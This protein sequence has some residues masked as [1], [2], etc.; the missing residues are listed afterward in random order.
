MGNMS[1]SEQKEIF[2]KYLKQ[3]IGQYFSEDNELNKAILY[4]LDA[5]GKRI[6][7]LLSL[8]F[9]QGFQGNHN[10][11][12]CAALAVEMIH[13]YSLIHDDLPAMD[14]DDFR[15]GRPTNH[16]VFGEATAILAGDSLLNL[17]P[18]FLLKELKNLKVDPQ[19]SLELV[20]LLLE[21]SGHQGMIKGQALDMLYEKEDLS[22]YDQQ[23]LDA[24]LR[25]I[26]K[27]K[28]GAIITWS[29][30]AG[31]YSHPDQA[32]IR[33]HKC[34]VQSIGQRIGLLF[35][36]VDDVLDATSTLA[37]LGKTPGKDERAGKLTYTQLYGLPST[38][39]MARS[40]ANE[41]SQ[42]V[43]ELSQG[44]GNWTII[45]EIIT[46]LKSKLAT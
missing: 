5:P 40:L 22:N 28:T 20:S 26:H 25:N 19:I 10:I 7:P 27:L 35:Q 6:R 18:E 12:L 16:K 8:G 13:T 9:S 1:S 2:E 4:S 44:Q 42:D 23:T 29:C 37:E 3:K 30:L 11:A 41:I 33:K 46:G 32:L 34:Q 24:I 14:N 21:Y 17:A 38:N 15:R 45:N 43:E 39:Q 36:I 31:L